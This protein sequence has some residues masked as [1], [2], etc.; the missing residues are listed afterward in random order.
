M[1]GIY[2]YVGFPKDREK[3]LALVK[4]LAIESEIRGVHSTGFVGMN[5]K[6]CYY[7]K[8]PVRAAEFVQY[9]DIE[10]AIV[11]GHARYFLGHN[12]WASCGAINT[13]NSHPFQGERYF[14][15]HNG[16]T[17]T[18]K[19]ICK[20]RK[21][22]CEG[23]TDSEAIL[24]L[25]DK[26]GLDNSGE[27]LNRLQNYSI[28]VLDYRRKRD[29][30]YFMRDAGKPMFIADLRPWLGIRVFVSEPIILERALKALNVDHHTIN[31]IIHKGWNTKPGHKY[32]VHSDGEFE[33]MGSYIDPELKKKFFPPPKVQTVPADANLVRRGSVRKIVEQE[34]PEWLE[35]DYWV[36]RSAA[37]AWR[38]IFH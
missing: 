11:Q 6:R 25:I 26:D 16:T 30:L 14:L 29:A 5:S 3:V 24:R 12:R 31:A 15:V 13:V 2:G 37:K 19:H 35:D 1:C 32:V 28:A 7:S 20:E 17:I 38:K 34:N 9:P 10:K 4:N 8:A 22:E 36:F 27:L 21:I 33:N 18:A 23:D